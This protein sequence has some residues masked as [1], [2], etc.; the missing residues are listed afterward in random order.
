M[1]R[2]TNK[3]CYKYEDFVFSLRNKLINTSEVDDSMYKKLKSLE[4]IE[5]ELGI[6]LNIL[7][8]ALKNG[9][10]YFAYDDQLIHD[11]VY[12]I[13]N[14]MDVGAHEKLSFSFKTF[15][16]NRTLLFEDYGK[17][18]ALDINDLARDELL[19]VKN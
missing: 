17:T 9:I 4:N 11:Y 19:W 15:L 12:L 8:S 3:D 16:E 18:W 5:E 1:S 10:Y 6:D 13:S 2:L 14:Y 7:F